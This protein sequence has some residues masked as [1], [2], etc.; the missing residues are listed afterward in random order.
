M[1]KHRYKISFLLTTLLYILLVSGYI[2]YIQNRHFSVEQKPKEKVITLALS[3]FVPPVEE[4]IEPLP[5]PVIEEVEPEPEIEIK[6]PEPIIQEEPVIEP[7]PI[8]VEK[9]SIQPKPVVKKLKK[10]KKKIKK[11]VKK[12]K[13]KKAVVKKK[14]NIK[15]KKRSVR[16]VAKTNPA[17]KSQFLA[18]LRAKINRAK[19]YPR[20]AQRRGMQGVVKVRFTIL[21]NGKVGNVSVSGPKVFHSSA[22]AAVKGAFPISVKNAPFALPETITLPIHYKQH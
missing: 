5:E 19:S 11:S 10:I 6:E 21:T 12:K 8:V 2:F 20:M 1:Q 22:R 13:V 7:K 16:S 4:V 14:K 17:K 15:R 3:K 9:P 18:R